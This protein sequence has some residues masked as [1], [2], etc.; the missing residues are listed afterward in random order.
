VLKIDQNSVEARPATGERFRPADFGSAGETIARGAENF[1]QGA[2]Q[3]SQNLAKIDEMYDTAA[4]KQADTEDLKK[5]IDIKS[6]ALSATGFDAQTAVANARQQ[7]ND[8]RKARMA[9]LKNAR[10]QRLYSEVFDQRGLQLEESFSNHLVKQVSEANKDAAAARAE[11]YRNDAIDTY[12]SPEFEKSLATAE[13]EV[14]TINQGA[15]NAVIG[16]AQSK[17]R[18]Q[19]YSGVV[20]NMLSDPNR[21]QEAKHALDEHAADILPEDETKLRKQLNPLIEED[22]TES[23]AGWAFTN[24]PVRDPLAPE[25]DATKGEPYY[26]PTEGADTPPRPSITG[27]S[28]RAAPIVKPISPTDPTR[29]KGTVT[30]TAAQHRA[31]GSG[32]AL[33]I[34]A[35]AGTPIYPPMSGKVIKNWWSQEGG[36][37]VLIEHPNG[38]V[39][40]YAHMR[41]QSALREGQEVDASTVIGGIGMTGTKATGPHVHYTV[42]LSRA[43]PKVD[44]NA[45][46]WG[47]TVKP[48]SVDWKEGAL[49]KFDA[50]DNAL[51]RALD[52]T[53]QRATAEGWSNRRYQSAVTRV[54]QIAGIQS[55]LYN[56]QQEDK[57]R[58]ALGAVVELGDKLT[59]RTQIPGF[60]ELDPQHQLSIDGIIKSNLNPSEEGKANG[61]VFLDLMDASI[62]PAR[63]ATFLN[64]DLLAETRITRSERARLYQRQSE[65]RQQPDG[66]LAARSDDAWATTNRYLPKSAKTFTDAQRQLFADRYMEAVGARQN[67]LKR[68]L[69]D[70]ERD[71]IARAL[72]V[73]AVRHDPSG[74]TGKGRMF[75]Y[76]GRQRQPGDVLQVDIPQTYSTIAPETRDRIIADLKSRGHSYSMRDVVSV[77][78]QM[79][80]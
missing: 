16:L 61:P 58:S 41:G 39:T 7:I 57:W 37:S 38:Y 53:Y 25:P 31:R 21:V 4:V 62:D 63:R 26:S 14:A 18:S 68:P 64:V 40:G 36:W 10:Q 43:G 52:R 3:A 42:R 20:E 54:R 55:E 1:A 35:P 50:Q 69:T 22:Q 47:T 23:D 2:D 45:V 75:E 60:G 44:P 48:E 59:S 8:I 67:E 56:Q 71:D 79:R 66:Q 74:D 76:I 19:V 11:V 24:S 15:G 51:G 32:N 72:V 77:F 34:A 17:L 65:L 49:T 80:R 46:D 9:S 29:G 13:S 70:R 28:S 5:I 27:P 30:N 73:P 78:L 33:D 6:Q 12:G